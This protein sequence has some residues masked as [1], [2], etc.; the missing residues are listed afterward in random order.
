MASGKVHIIGAGLAGLSAAVTCVDS[1]RDVVVHELARHAGGRC[2]SYFEPALGLNI[3]NG[4]HLLLSANDNALSFLKTIGSEDK[5]AGP[6]EAEFAFADLASDQR[7][8][9][10]PNEGLFPWWIFAKDRRVPGTGPLD[11]LPM[12]RLLFPGKDE[13]ID[14]II[15][16]S[17]AV[18]RA[19]RSVRRPR[20]CDLTQDSRAG[21]PGLS[22]VD[23]RRRSRSGLHRPGARLSRAQ[24]R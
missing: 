16:C 24:R 19:A 2:R 13:R 3:D 22:P 17:G 11:Y 8:D 9:F 6:N 10:H 12:T 7:W 20:E 23:R 4:N 15:D 18:Y 1:G 5:L 21:R 14:K